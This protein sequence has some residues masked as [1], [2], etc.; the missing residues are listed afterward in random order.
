MSNQQNPK[1]KFSLDTTSSNHQQGG[2]ILMEESYRGNASHLQSVR[3]GQE[4]LVI[5]QGLAAQ[6]RVP[7]LAPSNILDTVS[8]NLA[9]SRTYRLAC[10]VF[11]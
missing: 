2:L 11:Q 5:L 8:K 4:L 10:S 6:D 1:G 9:H 7:D 3:I